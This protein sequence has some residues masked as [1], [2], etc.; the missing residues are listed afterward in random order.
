MSAT[1]VNG[2]YEQNELV[3]QDDG[4]SRNS[5]SVSSSVTGGNEAVVLCRGNVDFEFPNQNVGVEFGFNVMENT[6]Y[7]VS[8][9]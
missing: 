4:R 7:L 6:T 3:D 8:L 2:D 9:F 5:A 1:L